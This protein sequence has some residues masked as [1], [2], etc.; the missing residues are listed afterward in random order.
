MPCNEKKNLYIVDSNDNILF[1]FIFVFIMPTNQL[2]K[3]YGL[4]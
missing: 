1:V 2:S 3:F 4:R